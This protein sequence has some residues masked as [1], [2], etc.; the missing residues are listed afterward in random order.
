MSGAAARLQL[1][2]GDPRIIRAVV[3]FVSAAVLLYLSAIFWFGWTGTAAALSSLG[4]KTILLAALLSSTSYLWRFGRWESSL[5][6][7]GHQVPMWRHLA[8]YLSGLGLTATPGKSGETF[9]SALLLQQGVR[10]SHSLAAFIVDRASDVLGM[11]LLGFAAAWMAGQVLAWAWMLAF[12]MLLLGSCIFAGFLRQPHAGAC[13]GWL[14]RAWQ[15]LP[16]KSGQAVLESWAGVWKLPRVTAYSVVAM[17]AYGTQALVFA[18]FCAAAGTG[19]PVAACVLI[20]VQATLFGAASMLPGGLGAMEAALVIQLT[21]RGVDGG[22]A[23]SMAIAIR[24]VTLWL[25]MAIGALSLLSSAKQAA[26]NA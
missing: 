10:V 18:W 11:C 15:R 16:V 23:V 20:F 12:G 22:V 7:F 4:L 25:G 24:L 26:R 8:I 5:R 9:R 2:L 13:W 17:I 6:C 21:E 14:S 3:L 1:A 19:V